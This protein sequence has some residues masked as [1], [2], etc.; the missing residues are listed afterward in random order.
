H[1]RYRMN[2]S[3]KESAWDKWQETL[4]W[5]KRYPAS[6]LVRLTEKHKKTN[7]GLDSCPKIQEDYPLPC[8]V[9]LS[10]AP[11]PPTSR[12]PLRARTWLLTALIV[13]QCQWRSGTKNQ[14][15]TMERAM[16]FWR[17]LVCV[18]H[19]HGTMKPTTSGI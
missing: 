10:K 1:T 11:T 18:P 6:S 9:P 7:P 8:L 2:L 5:Q 15:T 13:D 16:K 19:H 17:N 12:S 3:Y 4:R 14:H